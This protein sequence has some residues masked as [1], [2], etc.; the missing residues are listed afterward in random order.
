MLSSFETQGREDPGLTYCTQSSR[1][2][3]YEY[4]SASV[5]LTPARLVENPTPVQDLRE[6]QDTPSSWLLIASVG[7]GVRWIAQLLPF[8]R[9]ASVAPGFHPSAVH[10]N[11]D[12]HDTPTSA[13]PGFGVR[14]IA[15]VVPFHR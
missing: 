11:L 10:A 9:S 14:W 3:D 5:M 12:A 6:A 13:P 15:Q 7:F 4:R 1:F 2:S 8:Q